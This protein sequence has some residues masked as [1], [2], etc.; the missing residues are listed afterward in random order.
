MLH[1]SKVLVVTALLA[2]ASCQTESSELAEQGLGK[3]EVVQNLGL[4]A[5]VL[6]QNQDFIAYI[7]AEADLLK[8]FQNWLDAL[9]PEARAQYAADLEKALATKDGAFFEPKHL[10]AEAYQKHQESQRL[11]HQKI[12]AL[13]PELSKMESLAKSQLIIAAQK[14]VLGTEKS[15][16]STDKKPNF[17][18]N[19]ERGYTACAW[20]AQNLEESTEPC[21]TGFQ[22]GLGA[23]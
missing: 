21:W 20:S 8:G 3:A 17:V 6:A 22:T 23:Y 11:L 9:S 1:S 15:T 2:F 14:L 19:I 12:N 10:S 13:F 5:E 18:D 16:S 7:K 4:S